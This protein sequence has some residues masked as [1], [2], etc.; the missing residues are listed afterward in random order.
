[1]TEVGERVVGADAARERISQPA[2]RDPDWTPFC[3]RWEVKGPGGIQK[4]DSQKPITRT[5]KI[6]HRVLPILGPGLGG[7]C[8]E[9]L[10]G[11]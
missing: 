1:V 6:L 2:G 5:H 7:G 10:Q 8:A 9:G 3:T 11:A 4:G